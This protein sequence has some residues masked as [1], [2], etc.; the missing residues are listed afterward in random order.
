VAQDQHISLIYRGFDEAGGE[1][2]HTLQCYS[3]ERLLW[4]CKIR[5]YTLVHCRRHNALSVKCES[6]HVPHSTYVLPASQVWKVILALPT[7]AYYSPSPPHP[8]PHNHTHTHTLTH[9]NSSLYSI[10]FPLPIYSYSPRPILPP[11]A[12]SLTVRAP[13]L[14]CLER[15]LAVVHD[16]V[17]GTVVEALVLARRHGVEGHEVAARLEGA[18]HRTEVELISPWKR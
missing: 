8:H 9:T 10:T 7:I 14:A 15:H 17:R 2:S 3:A 4:K 11:H 12:P 1:V 13:S 6:S 5:G 16:D 18:L